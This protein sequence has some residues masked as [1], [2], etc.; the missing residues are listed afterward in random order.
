MAIG[1]SYIY[2]CD[3][4]TKTPYHKNVAVRIRKAQAAA[5]R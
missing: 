2:F 4:L 3:P 1:A 5:A